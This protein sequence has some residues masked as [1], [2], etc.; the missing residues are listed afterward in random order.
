LKKASLDLIG[1]FYNR[2]HDSITYFYQNK[3]ENTAI[4]RILAQQNGKNTLIDTIYIPPI[5]TINKKAEASGRGDKSERTDI[6]RPVLKLNTN[7]HYQDTLKLYSHSPLKSIVSA[8]EVKIGKYV[9]KGNWRISDIDPRVM[10]SDIVLAADKEYS[11]VIQKNTITSIYDKSNDSTAYKLKTQASTYYGT[12]KLQLK[13]NDLLINEPYTIKLI[14]ERGNIHAIKDKRTDH[15]YEFNFLEPLDYRLK[16]EIGA[17]K[18]RTGSYK[19]R[20]QAATV[21]QYKSVIKLRS[22]WINETEWSFD[23]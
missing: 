14:D 12:I 15:F 18:W 23:N 8:P 2:N 17:R 13:P 5:L 22:D 4:Y 9:V 19:Q 20:K 1:P 10:V 11:I 16:L 21:Y 7:A 3:I 6:L